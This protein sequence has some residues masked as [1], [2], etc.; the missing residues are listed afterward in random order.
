MIRSETYPRETFW[1]L[2]VSF[3]F[4]SLNAFLIS[5]EF[6]YLNIIPWVLL[7]VL[8]AF[9]SLD[10]ILLLIVFCVPLSI[11]L[12][13]LI[14]GLEFDAHLPTE[15]MMLGVLILIVLKYFQGEGFDRRI[16]YHPVSIAIYFN[17]IWII[18]T[19][20]TSSMFLVSLKFL[21]SRIWFV[22]TFYFLAAQ[23]FKTY[24]NMRKYIWVYII[25]ML[26]IIFVVLVKM[27]T[28]GFFNQR[29]AHSVVRPFFNDHTAYGASLAFLIPVIVGFI[30][31][32]KKIR[33]L[34]RFL[35]ILILVIFLIALILSY[36]RA[37]WVSL[38]GAVVLFFIIKL[39]VRFSFLLILGVVLSLFIYSYR[40]DIVIKL[41]QNRQDASR[42]LSEHV[43]SISNVATDASNLERLNRWSCAW[44]MF[45]EKPIFGWGPGAYMFQYAPFQIARERTIISTD[46]ANV[47]NAHSEYIGP[48]A[49][50][51][52][53]G[54]ITFVWI[55]IA[56]VLTGLRA[57]RRA[58]SRYV[59]TFVLSVLLGL[60][61]YLIHGLLNNFLDTDKASALF[62]GFIAIL[63]ATDL[64]HLKHE[65]SESSN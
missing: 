41:E 59:K 21:F 15:P 13:S 31:H 17:L 34:Y 1:V 58:R 37:A 25:P 60:S 22:L 23:F 65:S 52:L 44:R 54:P 55:V 35:G 30:F 56:A 26:V 33:G 9:Y 19:T 2:L 47:G 61:T 7:V 36:S 3:L 20:I 29:A 6:Y 32:D 8:L 51:G 46:F 53:F 42:V 11:E 64:D 40:N 57:Y 4:F 39:R 5:I 10:R 43:K 12:S 16:L 48:L 18:I 28:Y 62:W 27:S 49:E 50:S 63:V 14:Y 45:K 24:G 38:L